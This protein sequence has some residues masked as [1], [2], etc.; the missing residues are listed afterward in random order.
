MHYTSKSTASLHPKNAMQYI[1]VTSFYKITRVKNALFTRQPSLIK[2][3]GAQ[4]DND[5][6][7]VKVK[8]IVGL[9]ACI[10]V[11]YCFVIM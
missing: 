11:L 4:P 8:S 10:V 9:A 5:W 1:N 2:Y 3:T 7:V 6:K